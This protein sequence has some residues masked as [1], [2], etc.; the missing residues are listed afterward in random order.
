MR[1]RRHGPAGQLEQASEKQV[2]ASSSKLIKLIIKRRRRRVGPPPPALRCARRPPG[3]QLPA[4]TVRTVP[5]VAGAGCRAEVSGR[6]LPEEEGVAKSYL[7]PLFCFE[8]KREKERQRV[9]MK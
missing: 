1:R 4:R 5:G 3:G 7:R 9:G 6:V 2:I 8:N